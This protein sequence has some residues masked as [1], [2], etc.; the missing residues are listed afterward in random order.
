[1]SSL[2]AN[3]IKINLC[4]VLIKFFYY[5]HN[6]MCHYSQLDVK[7]HNY[8]MFYTTWHKQQQLLGNY[9]TNLRNGDLQNAITILKHTAS[10][11]NTN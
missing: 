3:K 1:M 11:Y 9:S 4:L 6:S 8:F 5:S 7:N 10:S 2:F